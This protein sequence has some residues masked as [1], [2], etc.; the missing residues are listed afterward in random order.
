M[1]TR[2]FTE[3]MSECEWKNLTRL[4]ISANPLTEGII[5]ILEGL[6][7]LKTL[8]VKINLMKNVERGLLLSLG[9]KKNIEVDCAPTKMNIEHEN[10]VEPYFKF[11]NSLITQTTDIAKKDGAICSFD[12]DKNLKI[13]IKGIQGISYFHTDF[14]PFSTLS[15]VIECKIYSNETSERKYTKCI[16]HSDCLEW[17]EEISFDNIR[18]SDLSCDGMIELT[19]FCLMVNPITGITKRK[20]VSKVECPVFDSNLELQQGNVKLFSKDTTIDGI[21]TTFSVDVSFENYEHSVMYEIEKIPPLK[22]KESLEVYE[23]TQIVLFNRV[24]PMNLTLNDLPSMKEWKQKDVNISNPDKIVPFLRSIPFQNPWAVYLA[25]QYVSKWKKPQHVMK[26]LRILSE[27]VSNSVFIK[28]TITEMLQDTTDEDFLVLLPYLTNC[29]KFD[30][31]NG[32]LT[33]YLV[34]RSLTS[35]VIGNQF[36]WL[37]KVESHRHPISK[38]ILSQ[39]M[40]MINTEEKEIIQNQCLF[41]D[42]IEKLTTGG[43]NGE[44]SKP[45]FIPFY[46][47]HDEVMTVIPSVQKFSISNVILQFKSG[48]VLEL[49]YS[50]LDQLFNLII[51]SFIDV[52]RFWINVPYT[53]RRVRNFPTAFGKGFSLVSPIHSQRVGGKNSKLS[54][55]TTSKS[56]SFKD[57]L[58]QTAAFD[59]FIGHVFESSSPSKIYVDNE[60]HLERSHYYPKS[61]QRVLGLIIL[62]ERMIYNELAE[63]LRNKNL[64]GPFKQLIDELSANFLDNINLI[65]SY[66]K[67]FGF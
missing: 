63:Y 5:P 53:N 51:N 47:M 42:S 46:S 50:P 8:I 14:K 45:L 22:F 49:E 41:L 25:K 55:F 24:E 18:I 54:D 34:R 30:S 67:P 59:A 65:I 61:F 43:M 15:F 21:D 36:F 62:M 27:S 7:S 57:I 56:Q 37:L 17:N 29:I 32:V 35:K 4:N 39:Y 33:Q 26:L 52:N 12:F 38:F 16:P 13:F 2:N 66:M 28:L 6:P 48:E 31:V 9:S 19:L 11:L 23:E 60:G 40:S 3:L 1:D 20:Y 58:L 44:F 10:D 64:F